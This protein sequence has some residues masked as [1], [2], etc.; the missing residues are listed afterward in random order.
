MA[1]RYV[2]VDDVTGQEFSGADEGTEGFVLVVGGEA[3]ELDLHRESVAELR[4]LLAPYIE[5]GRKVRPQHT[6]PKRAA[7]GAQPGSFREKR[8][9]AQ[10]VREWARSEGVHVSDRGRIP[11]DVL[12]RYEREVGG[13]SIPAQPTI[14]AQDTTSQ[15]KL[16]DQANALLKG[17]PTPSAGFTSTLFS[18]PEPKAAP[19]LDKDGTDSEDKPAEEQK[20]E[21]IEVTAAGIAAWLEQQG[22]DPAGIKFLKRLSLFRQ[23]HP[24]V[25]VKYMKNA[26]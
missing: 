24:G 26:S 15:R 10:A 17:K 6:A 18:S 2:V 19:E 1:K 9:H 7:A 22:I 16:T 21:V 4:K 20:P 14:P 11:S 25:E 8:A 5:A 23:A 12:E 13:A 3:V